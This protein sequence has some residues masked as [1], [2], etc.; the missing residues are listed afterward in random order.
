MKVM[1]NH[2]KNYD[3]RILIRGEYYVK[4]VA[5]FKRNIFQTTIGKQNKSDKK[6]TQN[7]KQPGEQRVTLAT[8]NCALKQPDWSQ[9]SQHFHWDDSLG[10]ND[11]IDWGEGD[12]SVIIL[13]KSLM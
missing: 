3:F 2:E 13:F 12:L 11:A 1:V 9:Q 7:L 6:S 4:C 5:L 8:I 10:T